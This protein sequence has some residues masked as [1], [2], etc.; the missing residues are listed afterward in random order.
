MV[1]SISDWRYIETI[2]EPS[3]GTGNIVEVL[4]KKEHILYG[5]RFDIDLIEIQ[6]ELRAILKDKVDIIL[7]SLLQ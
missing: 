3:A 7:G 4:A 6:P 5:N 2:L 1:N